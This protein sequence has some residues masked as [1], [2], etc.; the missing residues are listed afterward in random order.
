MA[1]V[2]IADCLESMPNRFEVVEAAVKRAREIALDG[3]NPLVDAGKNKATVVA[4]REIAEGVVGVGGEL[5]HVESDDNADNEIIEDI[6]Q[7]E[8]G[9]DI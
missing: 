7:D 1:R 4:L 5:K 2:T 3:A 8:E 9:S 6:A